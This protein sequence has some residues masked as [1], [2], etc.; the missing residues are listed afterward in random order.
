MQNFFLLILGPQILNS[1]FLRGSLLPTFLQN[2]EN[3]NLWVFRSQDRY[4][5]CKTN[6]D[7]L[8]KEYLW[9]K[10][11][12]PCEYELNPFY[13]FGA[14]QPLTNV[15]KTRTLTLPFTLLFFITYYVLLTNISFLFLPS[16]NCFFMI[17]VC[18]FFYMRTVSS[19]IL[20]VS[21]I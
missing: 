19:N 5:Y 17:C 1:A 21:S 8:L 16:K 18:F 14:V 15:T 2:I 13:C 6:F 11:L 10:T 12:L 3:L 9:P 20:S 4:F 7:L